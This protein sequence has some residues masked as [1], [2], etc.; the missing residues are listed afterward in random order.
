VLEQAPPPQLVLVLA[1][2]QEPAQ[3][4]VLVPE[5]DGEPEPV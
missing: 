1:Q 5:Q 3:G 4:E 2:A